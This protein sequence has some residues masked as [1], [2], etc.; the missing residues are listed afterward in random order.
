MGRPLFH[1]FK[2]DRAKLLFGAGVG[3]GLV[4]FGVWASWLCWTFGI[5]AEGEL[6]FFDVEKPSWVALGIFLVLIALPLGFGCWALGIAWRHWNT[7]IQLLDEGLVSYDRRGER[8]IRWR[9]IA[10][11]H[12]KQTHIAPAAHH[13]LQLVTLPLQEWRRSSSYILRLIDGTELEISGMRG[14]SVL[15]GLLIVQAQKHSIPWE[16]THEE[17]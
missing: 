2:I 1:E 9:E 5:P 7:R 15:V 6:P 12:E 14:E 17:F 3:V 4:L 10:A 16:I 11:I 8:T 13:P